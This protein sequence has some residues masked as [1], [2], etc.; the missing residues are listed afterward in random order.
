MRSVLIIEPDEALA[1]L[2][3]LVLKEEGYVITLADGL[4]QAETILGHSHFDA[5]LTEAFDQHTLFHF[6][7]RFLQRLRAAASDIPIVLCS[8]DTY[9]L[10]LRPGDFGLAEVICK[11]LDVDELPK[12][13]KK[14]AGTP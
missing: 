7:E 9:A 8:T 11:P 4:D 5:I 1:A 12:K 13:I 3:E 14:V 6:D 10:G 2:L